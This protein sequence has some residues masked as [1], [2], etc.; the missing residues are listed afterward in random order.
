MD[1]AVRRAI[2][3]YT[4]Q[5]LLIGEPTIHNIKQNC[6]HCLIKWANDC[7]LLCNLFYINLVFRLKGQSREGETLAELSCVLLY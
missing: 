7:F 6:W 2:V 1:R 3:Y 5:L 4:R